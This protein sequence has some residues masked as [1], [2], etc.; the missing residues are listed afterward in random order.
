[1]RIDGE[2]IVHRRKKIAIERQHQRMPRA[3][4]S[5]V[6]Q[7]LHFL[8]AQ[9]FRGLFNFF[10]AIFL[11]QRR[12]YFVL[13]RDADDRR[14]SRRKSGDAPA[15]ERH[16]DGVPFRAFGF[17]RGDE[18]NRVLIGKARWTLLF[19]VG[20]KPF[21]EI[22]QRRARCGR[23]GGERHED[24]ELADR[25]LEIFRRKRS[26]PRPQRRAVDQLLNG[27]KERQFLKRG[28]NLGQLADLRRHYPRRRARSFNLKAVAMSFAE[29]GQVVIGNSVNFA[30]DSDDL[31]VVLRLDHDGTERGQPRIRG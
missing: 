7:P 31:V 18:L 2:P 23:F 30:Q 6:K 28:A 5:D 15:E 19:H 8:A 11:V 10:F 24:V 14:I 20:A 27:G 1:M 4:D 3:R 9:D 17:L 22:R 21:G 13:S 26:K 16:D 12:N 25:V 29:H